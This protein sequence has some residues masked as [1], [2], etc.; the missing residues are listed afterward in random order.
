MSVMLKD[1]KS[2][3]PEND[4]IFRGIGVSPG[5]VIAP[6]TVLSHEE[7]P[8]P[9][10][11][12]LSEDIP[13]EIARLNVAL[14]ET[15]KQLLKIKD[16]LEDSLGDKDAHIFDAHLMIVD[17]VAFLDAV[18]KKLT[19]DL[20]CVE[21]IYRDLMHSYAQ[22]M[23]EVDDPYLAERASDILDVA[24]RVVNNLLGRNDADRY[25]LKKPSIIIAHDLTPSDTAMLDRNMVLGFATDIGSRT[26][27]TS[28]MARSLRIPATVALN[29]VSQ[30]VSSSQM[31]IV[32]GY[33]GILI[34]N[35]T[36]ATIKKYEVMQKKISVAYEKLLQYRHIP[37]VTKDGRAIALSA[38]IELSQDL[39]LL[40]E[41]GA[42][43]IGLYRTEFLFLNRFD[44]P[45]EDEQTKTYRE[46]FEAVTPHPII[47]RTLDIGGDK[48]LQSLEDD[49]EANPFLGW[50]A[51]RFCLAKKDIFKVQLRAICRAAHGIKNIKIMFPMIAAM[52]ELIEAKQLLKECMH[53]LKKENVPYQSKIE[54]GAMIEIPSATLIIDKIADEVSFVSIGT[55][56]LIQYMLAA[57]RT[58]QK[59]DYLYQ[60]AHPAI[61]K[62]IKNVV[63]ACHKKKVWVGVCGELASDILYTPYLIGL[64]VDGLSV[65]PGFVPYL[66][67]AITSL[68]FKK[69]QKLVNDCEDL[70]TAAEITKKIRKVAMESYGDLLEMIHE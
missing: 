54:V 48:L 43:G 26:S 9:Q 33:D 14:L 52:E 25:I 49:Q 22:S 28:I 56:D 24:H 15:R 60:P 67:K 10:E 12:I 18:K 27:H 39:P 50:R 16:H 40:K 66:K 23:R 62:T 19:D 58:N 34:V 41:N 37:A 70:C 47:I 61:L 13:N 31:A 3:V 32:D 63:K 17:D 68:N 64:G 20:M 44:F 2:S 36:E 57:D 35:P 6:L 5:I 21:T 11:K 55:N 38:N 65:G 69:N 46:V 45:S 8:I 53:E 42:E 30:K 4:I 51:I 1:I 59:V 7:L 29:H